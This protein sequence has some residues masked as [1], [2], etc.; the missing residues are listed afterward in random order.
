M[1]NSYLN[2]IADHGKSLL[3]FIGLENASNQELS[4]GSPSYAR[5][6]VTWGTTTNGAFSATN[7][8]IEFDVPAGANVATSRS[9]AQLPAGRSMAS[10]KCLKKTITLRVSIA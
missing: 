1:N 8:P 7:V 4:G 6:A 5:K 10:R 2:A 9:T 3:L